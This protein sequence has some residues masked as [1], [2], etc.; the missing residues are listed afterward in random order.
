[1]LALIAVRQGRR[2]DAMRIRDWF[3]EINHRG[4]WRGQVA[5]ILG[6]KERAVEL[7]QET[8]GFPYGLWLHRNETFD[9]LRDYPPFQVLMRPIG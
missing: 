8:K 4:A 2:D 9:S 5:A 1:M 3:E 7:F 6:D